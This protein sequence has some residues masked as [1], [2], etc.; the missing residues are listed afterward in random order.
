MGLILD[1]TLLIAAE[2]RRQNAR[3]MLDA[4]SRTTGNEDIAL[5][6]ISLLELAH[7]AARA[8]TAQRRTKRLQFIEE[9]LRAL[10]IHQ[11]T[12][13]VALRAGQ[14]YGENQA[15]GV[16]LPLADLLI[17]VTALELGYRIVTDNLRHFRLIPG[18]SVDQ[19]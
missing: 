3:E 2:R 1:S 13:S 11:V 7:G 8:D 14:I 16:S 5:S 15:K 19:L 4:I 6:V 18:L 12:V 17:G 10:P 9:I